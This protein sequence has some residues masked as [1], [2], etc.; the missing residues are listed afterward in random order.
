MQDKTGKKYLEFHQKLLT[1]RGQVDKAR[2]LAVAQGDRPRH[3]ADRA[4][5][6]QRRGA[7]LSLEESFQARREARPQR[8][9]EL[10]DRQRR[11]GGR[12]WRRDAAGK[13]QHRALRQG[14]LLGR[15]LYLS[16]VLLSHTIFRST[17]EDLAPRADACIAVAFGGCHALPSIND[18]RGS[19]ATLLATLAVGVTLSPAQSWPQR[20]VKLICRSDPA[21]ES[22]SPRA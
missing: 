21:A 15:A 18:L 22:T 7:R 16:A 3:G 4:R 2:A 11:R 14:D 17:H 9:A 13:G 10:R 19:P 1:G 20:T 5:L 8:H 6:G 12:G